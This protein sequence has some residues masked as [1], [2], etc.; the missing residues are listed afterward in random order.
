M[1][2]PNLSEQLCKKI[3]ESA[4]IEYH[5]LNGG[6]KYWFAKDSDNHWLQIIKGESRALI[7]L[8]RQT[9]KDDL[10]ILPEFENSKYFTPICID[11]ETF[12]LEY[13]PGFHKSWGGPREGAG[14]PSTNRKR[15]QYYITDEE[16]QL[17]RDYLQQ[18]R[19]P[20]K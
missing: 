13:G 7:Y 6:G 20:S 15:R 9:Y 3:L 5:D 16:D 4:K 12:E 11:L 10:K 1:Y 2:N 19:Q 18:L 14:R 17:L 8:K